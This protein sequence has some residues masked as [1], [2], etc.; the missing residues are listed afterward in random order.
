ME[1]NDSNGVPSV[2]HVHKFGVRIDNRTTKDE[3]GQVRVRHRVFHKWEQWREQDKEQMMHL[4]DKRR[5][6]LGRSINKYFSFNT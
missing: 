3:Y 4:D 1:F 6:C 2:P 5:I